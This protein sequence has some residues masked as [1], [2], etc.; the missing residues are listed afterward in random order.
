MDTGIIISVIFGGASIVLGALAIRSLFWKS[1]VINFG[2]VFIYLPIAI[3]LVKHVVPLLIS[4]YPT[5]FPTLFLSCLFVTLHL[6]LVI[7]IYVREKA[8]K[9]CVQA[10][11]EASELRGSLEVSK[12]F[13]ACLSQ[14]KKMDIEEIFKGV[15]DD[16]PLRLLR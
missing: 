15:E 16:P 7:A 14:F 11:S 5:L 1:I 6:H 8:L 3:I 2:Y 12:Q 10:R 13:E 4:G 9:Q